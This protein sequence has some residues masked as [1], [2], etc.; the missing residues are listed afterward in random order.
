MHTG[1]AGANITLLILGAIFMDTPLPSFWSILEDPG[2][3][4]LVMLGRC[5]LAGPSYFY[6][7]VFALPACVGDNVSLFHF[8]LILFLNAIT[9]GLNCT[10]SGNSGTNLKSPGPIQDKQNYIP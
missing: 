5:S 6:W 10:T 8:L 2:T 3:C 1:S 4:T 9:V 7:R